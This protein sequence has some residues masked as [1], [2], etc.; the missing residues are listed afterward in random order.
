M[1]S[2]P[3]RGS[4]MIVIGESVDDEKPSCTV[5]YIWRAGCEV[6]STVIVGGSG[7]MPSNGA[8]SSSRTTQEPPGQGRDAGRAI[9]RD[10]RVNRPNRADIADETWRGMTVRPIA[11]RQGSGAAAGRR[12][13]V[14]GHAQE[15]HD[16]GGDPGCGC[17][18]DAEREQAEQARSR[19]PPH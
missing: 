2:R 7:F 9:D 11:D 8:A 5:S 3:V 1:S 19:P 4:A 16:S 10:A 13:E 17:R 15:H 14:D 12:R 18:F 6:G